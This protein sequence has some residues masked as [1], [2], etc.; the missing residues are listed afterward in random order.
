MTCAAYFRRDGSPCS[1]EEALSFGSVLRDGYRIAGSILTDSKPAALRVFMHDAE[2]SVQTFA[3]SAEGQ[4]SIAYAQMCHRTQH[5]H[6]GDA[7][8]AW[9]DAMTADHLRRTLA[10]R[11]GSPFA[12]TDAAAA[13]A[14]AKADEARQRM[15]DQL[16][17]RT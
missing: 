9:T 11:T 13:D 6:L 4:A 15:I 7:A 12:I 2:K 8:P 16:T 5:G 14:K 3:D 1:A 10:T 17:G